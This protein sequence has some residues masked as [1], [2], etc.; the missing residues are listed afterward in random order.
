M[1][2]DMLPYLPPSVTTP[3]ATLTSTFAEDMLGIPDCQSE[4]C[5][6]GTSGCGL[7]ILG[8]CVNAA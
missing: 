5:D 4:R 6:M 2:Q 8:F 3:S 1:I 7:I